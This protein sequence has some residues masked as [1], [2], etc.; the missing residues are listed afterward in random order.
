MSVGISK[1]IEKLQRS[2]LWGDGIL[3]QKL[4]AVDWITV[5][6]S[7]KNGGLGIG[8]ILSKNEGMLAKWV[9]RFTVEASSLWKRVVCA[10]YGI[11][12]MRMVWDWQC[13]KASSFF[14]NVVSSLFKMGS[15]SEKVLKEGIKV[16]IG[17]EAKVRF[18]QYIK[19]DSV[20]IKKA[21][22]RIYAL[23]SDK[24]GFLSDFSHWNGSKWVWEVRPAYLDD[25]E[26]NHDPQID[27]HARDMGINIEQVIREEVGV[28]RGV[29]VSS[30]SD[31]QY[32]SDGNSGGKDD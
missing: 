25:D 2:F 19:V 12:D 13:M 15:N 29:T 28:G 31:D 17:D 20:L 23:A 14:M 26:G 4:H 9:W 24:G 30:F 11:D 22:P 10:K 16:V 6:K 7:K 3:K 5:C 8:R 32:T 21:F 27:S 1:R 18:W